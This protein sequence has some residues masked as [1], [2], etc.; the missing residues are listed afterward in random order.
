MVIKIDA[1][2]DF[3]SNKI[4]IYLPEENRY[5]EIGRKQCTWNVLSGTLSENLPAGSVV[6]VENAHLGVPRVKSKAQYFIESDLL[7]F[8]ADL[9]KNGLILK[10]FPEKQTGKAQTY[11]GLKKLIKMILNLSISI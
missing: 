3:G 4:F 8:Y 2:I 6:I 7:N 9:E 5:I 1:V 11:S 10:L